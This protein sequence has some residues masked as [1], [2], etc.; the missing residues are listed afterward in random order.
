MHTVPGAIYHKKDKLWEVPITSLAKLLDT[1]TF[2]DEIKFRV[3]DDSEISAIS[4]PPLTEEEI[5]ALGFNPYQHQIEGI[6][7][8]L[9]KKK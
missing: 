8:G 1:L 3:C 5:A 2:L 6:N 9:D 4:E 7:Y